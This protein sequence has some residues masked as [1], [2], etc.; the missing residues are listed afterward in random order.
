MIE[1]YKRKLQ[2]LIAAAAA[3]GIVLTIDL[4]PTQPL[5]M[6]G[7]TMVPAVREYRGATLKREVQP[8]ELD[9]INAAAWMH[10]CTPTTMPR[11]VEPGEWAACQR[12]AELPAVDECLQGFANDRTGDNAIMIVREV[13]RVLEAAP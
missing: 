8:D 10:K 7:Y 5:R 6:T 12:I 11:P 3:D 4:V 9:R 13:R 1:L 2:D